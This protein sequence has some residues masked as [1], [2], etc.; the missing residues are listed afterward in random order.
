MFLTVEVSCQVKV[1][2]LSIQDRFCTFPISGFRNSNCCTCT[3]ICPNV[4][5]FCFGQSII[6]PQS[7]YFFLKYNAPNEGG[8]HYL[9]RIKILKSRAVLISSIGVSTEYRL[10][11]NE[12]NEKYQIILRNPYQ[13]R[14][15]DRCR[16]CNTSFFILSFWLKHLVTLWN[17]TLKQTQYK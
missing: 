2:P 6:T 10:L 11:I 1:V 15:T 16:S 4:K 3:L 13:S 7:L 9:S 5:G 17:P 14:L 12:L 8:F